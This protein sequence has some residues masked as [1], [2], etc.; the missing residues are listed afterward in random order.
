M[1]QTIN[2]AS[3]IKRKKAGS[4]LRLRRTTRHRYSLGEARIR[5]R[6]LMRGAGRG[7][8]IIN[9]TPQLNHF[10]C[11][12]TNKREQGRRIMHPSRHWLDYD[13]VALAVLVIGIGMIELLA[14]SI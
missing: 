13:P 5:A 2:S 11:W 8:A 14:L 10:A 4:S 7:G 3:P 9:S 6:T 12:P 1:I